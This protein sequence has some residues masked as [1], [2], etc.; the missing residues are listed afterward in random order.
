M[1]SK[2]SLRLSG[3]KR[4]TKY[5]KFPGICFARSTAKSIHGRPDFNIHKTGIQ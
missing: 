3:Q 4:V 1:L 2:L 5:G